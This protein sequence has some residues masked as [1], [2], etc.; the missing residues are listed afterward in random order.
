MVKSKIYSG[1]VHT[2]AGSINFRKKYLRI[3]N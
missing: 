2:V 1:I 3:E